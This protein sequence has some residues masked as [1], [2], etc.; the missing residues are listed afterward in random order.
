MLHFCVWF[1][2]SD[3]GSHPAQVV[4]VAEPS[5]SPARWPAVARAPGSWPEL[6]P[7]LP[8]CGPSEQAGS[9]ARGACHWTWGPELAFRDLCL[10]AQSRTPG[11]KFQDRSRVPHAPG[12]E[13]WAQGVGAGSSVL[14]WIIL[15]DLRALPELLRTSLP[16]LS[17]QHV[18]PPTLRW[19]PTLGSEEPHGIVQGAVGT[20]QYALVP[21][22]YHIVTPCAP[23]HSSVLIIR[24]WY[25]HSSPSLPL[26]LS[27]YTVLAW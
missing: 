18:Q 4:S 20:H 1:C 22:R 11:T 13:R 23:P 2:S 8:P 24:Q 14:L 17:L 25:K 16:V 10:W 12:P 21:H 6:F 5:A 15:D 7:G 19:P 27:L 3:S 9:R 26:T